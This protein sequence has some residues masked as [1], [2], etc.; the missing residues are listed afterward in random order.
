MTVCSRHLIAA[1]ALPLLL[2]GGCATGLKIDSSYQSVS[3]DSRVQHLVLHFTAEDFP[4]SLRIL[5]QGA[6]SSHY[7]VSDRQGDT[8][9]KIYRL[10]DDSRRAY[11]AGVSSW[12]G[13]T[14]LNASSIGIEIVNRGPIK[15]P[16]GVEF[17]DFDDEQIDLVIELC[18]QIVRDHGIRIDRVVGHSDIAPTR[19]ND[20]G[21]KFP[22]KRFA[23]AGLILWPDAALV[24]QKLPG[25]Q[26]QLPDVKW[27]QE[28]MQ[29]HGFLVPQ[30]GD[31]DRATRD[32]IAAFQMKYRPARY[33]GQPDAE[34]A[35][36]VDA[37]VLQAAKLVT[38]PARPAPGNAGAM[39]Q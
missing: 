21:P 39:R 29:S 7:L 20:P 32:V 22:W 1:M 31:L 19:K 16:S 10:V 26:Q 5:T 6:V 2:L 3:Q 30:H 27:F 9:P 28:R 8:A 35:A 14:A 37:L 11:H 17:Q 34:T 4:R 33:D 18:R 23:D 25:Y 15:G 38:P 36:L 13:A 12:K 24:A